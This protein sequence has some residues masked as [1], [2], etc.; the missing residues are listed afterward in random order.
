MSINVNLAL[1]GIWPRVDMG[2][3]G[4]NF[5]KSI[6]RILAGASIV[7]SLGVVA[8]PAFSQTTTPTTS[9]AID[10]AKIK[11]AP[12]PIAGAGLPVLAVGF[13]VYWLIRRRR[14]AE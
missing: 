14:K 5:M 1:R 2:Q 12:G 9:T 10:A 6:T 4:V 3:L 13:G 7:A 8:L 11:P